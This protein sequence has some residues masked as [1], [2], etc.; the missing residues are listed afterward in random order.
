M[1][2]LLA[3]LLVAGIFA[4][5]ALSAGAGSN[6]KCNQHMCPLAQASTQAGYQVVSQLAVASVDAAEL[7]Q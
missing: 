3:V 5:G 7:E 2:I 6:S 4:V 1:R